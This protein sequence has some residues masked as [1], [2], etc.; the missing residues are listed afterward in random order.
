MGRLLL[1]RHGQASFL[2]QDYDKL[3][4]AGEAQSQ[5]LGEYWT[6]RSVTFDRVFSGPRVRQRDTAK[7]VGESYR[8]AG[9]TFPESVVMQ[10]FD[11]YAADAVL[12]KNLPHLVESDSRV[13]ELHRAFVASDGAVERRKN[14]QKMFE[15][16]IGRWVAAELTVPGVESW[17]EF[18][19]RVNRGLAQIA[20]TSRPGE[21]VAV[22]S[23]G[24]PIA[25]AMQRALNL[26]PR[27]T[28]GTLWMSRNCSYSEFL[29]SGD[30]FTL[31]A[32]NAFPHLDDP[33][34]LTYR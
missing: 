5:L 17:S 30:R 34:L 16:V 31:S 13:R 4:S 22:F 24:G 14:F 10:E 9:L 26:S 25:V 23:S 15:I 21:E 8:N 29:F 20:S 19:A 11:E 6:R 32:F 18:C 27:D 7:I 3:S 12:E 33:A 1:V 2:E 28:L